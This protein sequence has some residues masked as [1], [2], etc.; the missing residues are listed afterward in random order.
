MT[1]GSCYVIYLPSVEVNGQKSYVRQDE[2]CH[3]GAF[4]FPL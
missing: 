4:S 3:P 1:M 2:I